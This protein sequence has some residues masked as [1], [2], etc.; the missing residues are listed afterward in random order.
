M[1]NCDQTSPQPPHVPNMLRRP[2]GHESIIIEEHTN[3]V[4]I[5]EKRKKKKKKKKKIS[6]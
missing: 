4:R 1:C 6:M 2:I 5:G 3:V